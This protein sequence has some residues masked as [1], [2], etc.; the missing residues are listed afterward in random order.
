MFK[1]SVT[2]V[3]IA[4]CGLS[5]APVW[6]GYSHLYDIRQLPDGVFEVVVG[7]GPDTG[8]FWCGAGSYV[9]GDLNA[10]TSTRIYVLRG[11]AG[12]AVKFALRAPADVGAVQSFSNSVEI[13]GNSLS[14][15]QARQHCYD[16]TIAE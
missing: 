7:V 15:S 6:A 3:A 1:P 8:N 4:V 11:R 5:T 13:V 9:L 12:G 10:A 14:A 2:A 16:K